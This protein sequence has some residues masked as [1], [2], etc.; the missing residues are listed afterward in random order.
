[1]P[2]T[3]RGHKQIRLCRFPSLFFFLQLW[4]CVCSCGIFVSISSFSYLKYIN[5]VS[6]GCSWIE[7]LHPSIKGVHKSPDASLVVMPF[8][9]GNSPIRFLRT[10][11]I[12]HYQW[13]EVYSLSPETFLVLIFLSVKIFWFRKLF[14]R[15]ESNCL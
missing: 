7:Q 5:H 2:C 13:H 8:V 6:V 1:M 15:E 4:Y 9:L 12:F 14:L 3:A 10:L 11:V